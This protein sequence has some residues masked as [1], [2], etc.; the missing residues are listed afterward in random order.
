[1]FL[2]ETL[3]ERMKKEQKRIVVIGDV[4]VDRWIHGT[5]GK[6]QDYCAKFVQGDVVSV[7]GGAANAARCLSHWN[8]KTSLYGF[9][10]ND[11]PVKSR[12]VEEGKIV[13][14]ADD[15]GLATR[16]KGYD[17]ARNLSLEM[18]KHSAGVLL[19]DYDKGFLTA[20]F[21]RVVA[22]TCQKLGVPCVSDAKREPRLY[23]GTIIKCNGDY[24]EK[25]HCDM[26]SGETVIVTLG[27]LNPIFWDN[28]AANGL[29]I[30][31]KPVKLVN[32]V[33]AGDCFGAHLVLGLVYG[34]SLK[35]ATVLA[36][37]AGRVY[38]QHEHNRP[39]YPQEIA[40]DLSTAS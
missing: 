2:V 17:W 22:D 23:K 31:F 20:D 5:I 26:S 18:L 10:D 6:C 7:P 35:E 19:S 1:M 33:G 36:H 39:P 3:L 15:D 28:G 40:S 14:R 8:L 30:D 16:A 29:G 34:L 27:R 12:Y 25:H 4:M 24:I 21:I 32:H 9:A 13:F 37:S 11:C 38:V